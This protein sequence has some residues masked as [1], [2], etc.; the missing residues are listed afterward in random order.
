[1]EAV[2]AGDALSLYL[3]ATVVMNAKRASDLRWER[4]AQTA[5]IDQKAGR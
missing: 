1:M 3:E 2:A 4:K 5:L